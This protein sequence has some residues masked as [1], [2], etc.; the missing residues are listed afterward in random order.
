MFVVVVQ[1]LCGWAHSI[2]VECL[3]NQGAR[4]HD[5]SV[6]MLIC[7]SWRPVKEGFHPVP[8][9]EIRIGVDVPGVV[10]QP[11]RTAF[12]LQAQGGGAPYREGREKGR[13]VPLYSTFF[14]GYFICAYPG[15]EI[16]LSGGM[17]IEISDSIYGISRKAKVIHNPQPTVMVSGV[18]AE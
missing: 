18:K 6:Y 9:E 11:R 10:S 1:V 4:H 12:S 7:V 16:Y 8:V 13:I 5:D 14:Y 3:R 2:E 17:F 15:R